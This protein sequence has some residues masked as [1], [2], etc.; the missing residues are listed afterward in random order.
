[1]STES[2]TQSII[3]NRF[4]LQYNRPPSPL[5]PNSDSALLSSVHHFHFVILVSVILNTCQCYLRLQPNSL[6]SSVCQHSFSKLVS[7]EIVR[8]QNWW[9]VAW[10][11]TEKSA[12]AMKTCHRFIC[13]GKLTTILRSHFRFPF[14]FLVFVFAIN[15]LW[16]VRSFFSK[17]FGFWPQKYKDRLGRASHCSYATGWWGHPGDARARTE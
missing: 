12:A 6:D 5:Y 7:N 13:S 4:R 1:M 9:S 16:K 14:I 15:Y 17:L 10:L 3:L 11:A 2:R 8:E